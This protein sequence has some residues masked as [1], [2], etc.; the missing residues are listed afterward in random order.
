MQHY[1]MVTSTLL[2]SYGPALLLGGRAQQDQLFSAAA[3]G[4]TRAVATLLTAGVC[5]D[6]RNGSYENE[7][8]LSVAIRGGHS[9][10]AR[11]L[12]QAGADV[13]TPNSFGWTPLMH[14]V[15][16]NNCEIVQILLKSAAKPNTT[17]KAG[18][19]S[20]MLAQRENSNPVILKLLTDAGARGSKVTDVRARLRFIAVV[21]TASNGT[22]RIT[23]GAGNN[24]TSRRTPVRKPKWA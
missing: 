2:I 7:S 15:S 10:T 24:D 21:C 5:P 19:T 3:I 16:S 9:P 20:L 13:N 18:W 4:D 17:N 6:A 8:A 22:Q 1:L 11:L 12:I 14:A 23:G